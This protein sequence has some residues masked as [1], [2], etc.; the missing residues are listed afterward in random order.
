V[1]FCKDDPKKKLLFICAEA[2]PKDALNPYR[3]EEFLGTLAD[4]YDIKYKAVSKYDEVCQEIT[5]ASKTGNLEYVILNMHGNREGMLLTDPWEN[6]DNWIHMYRNHLSKCFSWFNP[7]GKI[8][9]ISCEV[10]KQGVFGSKDNIA[11]L[12]SDM[13]TK[14][15]I[16]PVE[17]SYPGNIEITSIDPLSIYEDSKRFYE[18]LYKDSEN[19]YKEFKPRNKP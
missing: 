3:N 12:M 15:V 7:K 14:P 8:I 6:I 10:G 18:R 16:A 17:K 4:H 13:A 2:D 9:L 19:N 11:G 5:E 1:R